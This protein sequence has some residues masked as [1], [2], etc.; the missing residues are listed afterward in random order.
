M[1][2]SVDFPA[3]DPIMFSL[4]LTLRASGDAAREALLHDVVETGV[5]VREL[6]IELIYR[7]FL[8]FCQ[9]VVSSL[10]VARKR[11]MLFLLR[12]VKG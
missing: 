1:I 4:D 3:R 11:I 2:A 7:V 9:Y 5:I 10:N 6:R 12:D 8:R